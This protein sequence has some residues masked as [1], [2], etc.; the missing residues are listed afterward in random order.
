MA[1]KKWSRSEKL[2][3]ALNAI[4]AITRRE[5]HS[6]TEIWKCH[7]IGRNVNET[8]RVFI[9]FRCDEKY[10]IFFNEKINHL[11]LFLTTSGPAELIQLIS[12]LFLGKCRNHVLGFHFSK[13]FICSLLSKCTNIL[14]KIIK[15]NRSSRHCIS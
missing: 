8:T 6:W 3:I 1:I 15:K 2:K 14:Y 12:K 4:V 10:E 9:S 11:S 7:Q 5:D 13:P